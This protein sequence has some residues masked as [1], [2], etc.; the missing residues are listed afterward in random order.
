MFDGWGMILATRTPQRDP[1]GQSH[2]HSPR[3]RPGHGLRS[4]RHSGQGRNPG[5]RSHDR[6]RE[7]SRSARFSPRQRH[8]DRSRSGFRSPGRNGSRSWCKVRRLSPSR[9]RDRGVGTFQEHLCDTRGPHP[10]EVHSAWKLGVPAVKLFPASVRG[11]DLIRALLG[12]FTDM[13]LIPTGGIND[14]NAPAYL[15]AGAVA[16]GVGSWLTSQD[17]RTMTERAVRLVQ[18]IS[19][20]A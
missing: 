8:P 2:P 3:D 17:T 10:T 16:V 9:W 11:P 13:K 12:P 15:A 4:L 19:N 20:D 14:Q 6:V 7:R 5:S 18:V 1:R